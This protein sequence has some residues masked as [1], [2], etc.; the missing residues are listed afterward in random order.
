MTVI[1]VLVAFFGL[2]LL[3][4]GA[5]TAWVL[6]QRP[7]DAALR[8]AQAAFLEDAIAAGR[9]AEAQREFPEGAFFL[10]LLSGLATADDTTRPP[11]ERLAIVEDRLA[12]IDAPD[13]TAPFGDPGGVPHGVFHQGWRLLLATER[14]ELSSDPGPAQEVRDAARVILDAVAAD[15][16]HFAPAYP[17]QRWPVDTVVALG[18]VARADDAVGVPG[19]DADLARWVRATRGLRDA[20]A[21]L[22]PH[23]VAPDGAPLEGPRGTSAS[24]IA[25]FMPDIDRPDAAAH[26]DAFRTAFVTREAG[27]VGVREYPHGTTGPGDVDSGPLVLGVSLSASA[28]GAAAARSAGAED[29]SVTL[30]HQ[31]EL[32]GMP[33][34]QDGRRSYLAGRV[35]VGDAFLAWS[36]TIPLRTGVGAADGPE[37]IL[38]PYAVVP[39]V[40]GAGLLLAAVRGPRRRAQR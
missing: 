9:A 13:V 10:H 38:W 18:A 40:L 14:A 2:L 5:R 29:L 11:A 27:L 12:A 24:L 6:E 19:A 8:H 39:I 1:R 34:T 16:S 20:H 30:D 21:G 15:P 25:T 4:G 37:A 33:W 32:L 31:A 22:Y 35:P 36:R 23:R 3:L 28:V 7:P 26:W 17:G